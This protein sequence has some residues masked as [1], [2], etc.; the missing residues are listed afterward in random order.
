M[1]RDVEEIFQN[2]RRYGLTQCF[3]CGGHPA[4]TGA[5]APNPEFGRRI[6]AEEG[7]PHLVFYSLYEAC[8]ELADRDKRVEIAILAKHGF[9]ARGVQ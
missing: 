4:F 6:G 3:L 2:P 7:K 8:F 1:N 9:P 5:F